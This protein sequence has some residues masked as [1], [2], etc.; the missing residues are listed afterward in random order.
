MQVR[1]YTHGSQR[2]MCLC[3]LHGKFYYY[4]PLDVMKDG[5]DQ[6]AISAS[7]F[8]AVVSSMLIYLLSSNVGNTVLHTLFTV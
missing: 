7:N 3:M 4:L 8:Q 1:A 5:V 6:I 2:F